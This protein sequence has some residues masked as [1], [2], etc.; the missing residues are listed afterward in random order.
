MENRLSLDIGEL[1]MLKVDEQWYSLGQALGVSVQELERI[2]ESESSLGNRK[3]EM[4]RMWIQNDPAA[5]LKKL[6]TALEEINKTELAEDIRS[7]DADVASS[8]Y[9]SLQSSTSS[10]R[11]E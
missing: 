7:V 3:L 6:A 4:F 11:M 8:G 5:S 1:E 9:E 10:V 2:H